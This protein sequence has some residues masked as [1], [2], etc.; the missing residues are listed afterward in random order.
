[1]TLSHT[2]SCF[3][4]LV[5]GNSGSGK[6]NFI[7]RFLCNYP[8]AAKV[9]RKSNVTYFIYNAGKGFKIQLHDVG[10]IE[11]I[12]RNFY[13]KMDVVLFF[14]AA[15]D[16]GTFQSLEESISLLTA[17]VKKEKMLSSPPRTKNETDSSSPPPRTKSERTSSFPPRTKKERY[18]VLVADFS[19][20]LDVAERLAEK[21][22]K[23]K[24][25]FGIKRLIESSFE[26][27]E[28]TSSVFQTILNEVIEPKLE[29]K[30]LL[31]R[32]NKK[33]AEKCVK[34]FLTK[35]F[36]CELPKS[37]MDQ[38]SRLDFS[39]FGGADSENLRFEETVKFAHEI[40]CD[41]T[42]SA[43]E[44]LNKLMN[45]NSAFGDLGTTF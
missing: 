23:L 14:Y 5:A 33:S 36:P 1:M 39:N 29:E 28:S 10:N 38:A 35:R 44:L 2:V 13:D 11:N 32:L 17:E 40:M 21:A 4:V 19:N 34:S 15:T 6:A 42:L 30:T 12:D 8:S 18:A 25:I 16:P 27:E 24:E 31:N 41:K 37:Y 26:D 3:E 43:K 7:N 9:C 22:K 20:Q 45:L